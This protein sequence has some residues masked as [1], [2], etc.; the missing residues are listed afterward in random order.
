MIIATTTWPGS[1]VVQPAIERPTAMRLAETEYQRVTDAVDALRP[2]DWTRPTDCTAWNVRQLVAHITGQTNLF[3]TPLEVMRQMR[4]AQARQ[5]P[6]QPSVDALT[7]FQVEERQHLGP[8]ELRA[9]LHRVGPRG[10]R[11]RRRIP[12]FVRHR[13]MPGAEIING[14]PESWSFGYLTDVILTRDPWMHRLDLARATTR[15]PMLTADHDGV[16]VADVVAEWAR[17]HGQSYRLKLT[18]P[19][20]G[21][22]SSGVGGEEIVMDAADFCRVVSGRPAPD[23][24][25]SWGLLATQ[26]PF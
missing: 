4:A 6:G 24:G 5:Q 23:G 19:A 8:E 20:G 21:S 9:E 22:W 7:G 2:E 13:R 16:I 26:V 25:Q 10:A 18:G 17:R 11:G 1:S 14:E 3:S 15:D 12:G